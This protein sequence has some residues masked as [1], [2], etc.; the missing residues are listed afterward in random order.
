MSSTFLSLVGEE[1]VKGGLLS[2]GCG[3]G[4]VVGERGRWDEGGRVRVIWVGMCGGSGKGGGRE[5]KG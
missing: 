5:G 4:E 1:K 2:E 3:V